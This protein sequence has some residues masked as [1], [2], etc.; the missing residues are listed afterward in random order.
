MR[1]VRRDGLY[2]KP[3]AEWF[4][5]ILT[6]AG[7]RCVLIPRC[8]CGFEQ[9]VNKA[10][11]KT[12]I[13]LPV[14]RGHGRGPAATEK[15]NGIV[16]SGGAEEFSRLRRGLRRNRIGGNAGRGVVV[17]VLLLLMGGAFWYQKHSAQ[18]AA[19][20]GVKPS[21]A[22]LPLKNLNTDADSVYFS[23]GITDEITTKL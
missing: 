6:A 21:V 18:D 16:A 4:S 2:R 17:L 19:A 23:D 20:V 11:E 14:G 8:P 9:V 5:A 13:A 22:V 7:P 1:W 10:L 15:G 12:A 3:P